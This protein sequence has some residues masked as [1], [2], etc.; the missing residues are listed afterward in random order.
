MKASEALKL[1]KKQVNRSYNGNGFRHICYAIHSEYAHGRIDTNLMYKLKTLIHCRL[2]DSQTLED[3]LTEHHGI[4]EILSW[5][6]DG[7]HYTDEYINY[8]CKV[9]ETRHAWID[10]LIKE[11]KA[12]GD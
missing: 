3:W 8:Y 1:V 12:K 10:S 7:M 11:F 2:N 6:H 9:Q 4:K 5:E